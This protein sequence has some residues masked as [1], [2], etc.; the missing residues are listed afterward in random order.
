MGTGLITS[1]VP[2]PAWP[3]SPGFGLAFQGSGFWISPAEPSRTAQAWLRPALAQA[4][5]CHLREGQTMDSTLEGRPRGQK[6]QPLPSHPAPI[7]SGY[8]VAVGR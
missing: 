2:A 3:K 6:L 5:A 4:G 1:D 8:V 7:G